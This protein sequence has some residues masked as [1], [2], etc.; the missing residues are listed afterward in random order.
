[1]DILGTVTNLRN[2]SIFDVCPCCVL[3]YL[4]G[5]KRIMRRPHQQILYKSG[6]GNHDKNILTTKKV[7]IKKIQSLNQTSAEKY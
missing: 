6:T 4:C 5:G 1:M 7:L 2:G 3:K